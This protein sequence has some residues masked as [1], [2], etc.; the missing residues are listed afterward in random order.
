M[1]TSGKYDFG[2]IKKVGAKS[3]LL[4]LSSNPY[5]IWVERLKLTAVLE[6][7]LEWLVN[8]AANNG[9]VLLNLGAVFVEGHFDQKAFDAA[10]EE[11]LSEVEIKKGKLTPAQVKAIDDKVIIAAR[12]FF[13]FTR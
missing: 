2:G 4:A 6:I 3:L 10:L 12:K 1:A 13:V 8:W 9:L 5:F 11:G 7:L